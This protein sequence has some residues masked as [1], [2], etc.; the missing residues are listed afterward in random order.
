MLLKRKLS[1]GATD[2]SERYRPANWMRAGENAA[3]TFETEHRATPESV[4]MSVYQLVAGSLEGPAGLHPETFLAALGAMAGYGAR[5]S[6]RAAVAAGA[7]A[8]DFHKP[9]G[10]NRAH[11]LV[12]ENVN[13]LVY[14]MRTNSVAAVLATHLMRA[15][16][17]WLPDINAAIQHNFEAINSPRYPDYT[18]PRKHFPSIP[19]QTLLMMLWEKTQRALKAHDDGAAMAPAVL[20][21]AAAHAAIVHKTR[22]PI[23]ISGQLVLETAIAMSKLDY[24]L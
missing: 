2:A 4:S 6:V 5:W 21:M 9:A 17:N 24:G 20:A 18:V 10:M 3:R 11:V 22:V 16:A 1:D 8:Y 7:L 12:S 15:G 14:D 23:E 19:P 13:R